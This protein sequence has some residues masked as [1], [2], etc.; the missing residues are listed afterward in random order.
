MV[1]TLPGTTVEVSRIT[2]G[3]SRQ[4]F[5]GIFAAGGITLCQVATLTGLEPSAIQN[6][7]KRGFVSSPVHRQYTQNQLSRIMI[8]NLL[9]ETLQI[10]HIRE[11][12]SYL[13]GRLT[14][15]SD[16]IISDSELYHTYVDMLARHGGFPRHR[17]QLW[18]RSVRPSPTTWNRLPERL[19]GWRKRWRLWRMP[20]RRPPP[21]ARRRKRWRSWADRRKPA[22][23]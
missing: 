10:E 12:L 19:S 20:M 18:E 3:L 11:M 2:P 14:D 22:Y 23:I 5:S 7:V 13:N 1:T 21:G 17:R 8:I 15:E 4:L 9:R 6:W 16:D